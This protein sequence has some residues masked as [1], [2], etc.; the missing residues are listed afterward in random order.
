M[1]VKLITREDLPLFRGQLP[2]DLQQLW[3]RPQRQV[4]LPVLKPAGVR[5]LLWISPAT[6]QTL[7]L[8]GLL[9]YVEGGDTLSCRTENISRL[10][11]GKEGVS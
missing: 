11:Q 5:R 8:R 1:S 10:L 4:L 3:G 6:L 9:P 2:E 7:H